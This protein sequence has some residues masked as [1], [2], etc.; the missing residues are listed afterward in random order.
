MKQKQKKVIYYS[1]VLNDEFSTKEI[2]AKKIDKNYKYQYTFFGIIAH[3]ILYRLIMIPCCYFYL[4]I[5]FHHKIV[6]KEKLKVNK[7][8]GYFIYGNHTQIVADAYI[9]TFI[10]LNKSTYV[11]THA[12]N[13]SMKGLGKITPY[14]GAI[15]LPDDISS[16]RHFLKWIENRA[17]KNAICIYP[18]R[19]LW[20][21][22]TK[23]RPF[24]EKAFNYPVKFNSPVYCFTNT[25][26]KRKNPNK[27]KIV[28][29]IDGPFYVDNKISINENKE[30][31]RNEVYNSMVN[32][33]KLNEIEIIE[34]KEKTNG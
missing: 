26:K 25:Y 34:Y 11:I 21:Y 32:R 15:P 22:Y 29:Y 31:L 4:K 8:K 28:T 19:H 24:D 3:F 1:D 10:S 16:M 14:L 33:S 20:P 30:K 13:V 2:K 18:E 17:E 6:G 5:K 12:N 7:N 9:P 23:I 27:V